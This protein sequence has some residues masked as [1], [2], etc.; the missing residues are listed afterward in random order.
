M[1][2]FRLNRGSNCIPKQWVSCPGAAWARFPGEPSGT[3]RGRLP[4]ASLAGSQPQIS[5]STQNVLA[6]LVVNNCFGGPI[7]LRNV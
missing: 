2:A 7:G 5:K 6:L 1:N 3:L 4:R